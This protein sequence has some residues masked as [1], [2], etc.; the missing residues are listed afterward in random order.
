MITIPP[1]PTQLRPLP[2]LEIGLETPQLRELACV[3]GLA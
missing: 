1:M 2:E 3:L